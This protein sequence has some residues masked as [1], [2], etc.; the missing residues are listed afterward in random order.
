[1]WTAFTEPEVK[2]LLDRVDP[3]E[4]ASIVEDLRRTHGASWRTHARLGPGLAAVALS[5]WDVVAASTSVDRAPLEAW[6][7]IL[8]ACVPDPGAAA[9]AVHGFVR[10]R[11]LSKVLTYQ[12]GLARFGASLARPMCA[13]AVGLDS[14]TRVFV[15]RWLADHAPQRAEAEL[16][17]CAGDP[18][19][20]VRDAALAGLRG[21]G[22]PVIAGVAAHLA[23]T[24]PEVRRSIIAFLAGLA[25]PDAL[26]PLRGA[27]EKERSNP[28]KTEIHKAL[29]ACGSSV[30]ARASTTRGGSTA[31]DP[32]T[33]SASAALLAS[34]EAQPAAKLP[35][36]LEELPYPRVRVKHEG[37]LS[38]KAIRWLL[39]RLALEQHEFTDPESRGLRAHLVDEDCHEL[40]RILTDLALARGSRADDKWLVYQRAILGSEQQ[41]LTGVE[42]LE[43]RVTNNG[44]ARATWTLDVLDRHASPGALYWLDFFALE[45]RSDAVRRAASAL[46]EGTRARLGS[47]E[48]QRRVDAGLPSFPF[49]ADGRWRLSEKKVVTLSGAGRVD[50]VPRKKSAFEAAELA[51]ISACRRTV[52]RAARWLERAMCEGRTWG[53]EAFAATFERHPVVRVLARPLLFLD[54]ASSTLFHL[55]PTGGPREAFGATWSLGSDASAR[56]VHPIHLRG[57]TTP[58]GYAEL[59]E[60]LGRFGAPP[61]PQLDRE[62]FLVDDCRRTDEGVALD[63]PALRVSP[64]LKSLGRRGWVTEEDSDDTAYETTKAFPGGWSAAVRHTGVDVRFLGGRAHDDGADFSLEDGSFF[65]EGLELDGPGGARIWDAPPVLFSEAMRDVELAIRAGARE[66][67][68][69]V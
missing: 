57:R 2:A 16:L 34:I 32:S 61:F 66:T 52:D 27:L 60:L 36:F 7:A 31:A 12:R 53:R 30:A 42:D 49:D 68:D 38:R 17:R 5:W 47:A 40:S 9:A 46:L 28:I 67:A 44:F 18:A 20:G 41:V 43:Q 56:I 59:R 51:Q 50:Y 24:S 19:R 54:E 65:L 11:D 37:E 6:L 33:I 10:L 62:V 39:S 63:S 3:V 13:A 1:M 15:V 26:P 14:P 22:P 58:G 8:D 55:H 64:T 23:S 29:L 21:L 48:V 69:D 35:R 45:A 25:H 4:R